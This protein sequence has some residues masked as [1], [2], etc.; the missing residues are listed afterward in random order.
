MLLL[1]SL[2]VGILAGLVLR[3]SLWHLGQLRLRCWPLLFSA[4]IAQVVIFSSPVA[5]SSLIVRCGGILYSLTLLVVLAALAVNLHI[6]GMWLVMLG[7]ALNAL[8]IVVNGGQMPVDYGKLEIA[9]GQP[10]VAEYGQSFINTAPMS[11]STKLSVLGDVVLM[12]SFLP[13]RNV[14][15]IGDVLIALGTIVVVTM[16][17]RQQT[18]AQPVGI[19]ASSSP[20]RSAA[21]QPDCTRPGLS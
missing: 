15:S 21:G 2:V 7:A 12:P 17:M 10:L 13:I 11:E 14:L 18:L 6:K 16:G 5:T 8:V 1:S 4:L 19:E 9:L 3:G 20:L